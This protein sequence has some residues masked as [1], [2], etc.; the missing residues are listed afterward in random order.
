MK[1]RV[2]TNSSSANVK[3]S[4]AQLSKRIQL[5][6]SLRNF[7]GPVALTIEASFNAICHSAN[8]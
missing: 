6:G 5:G 3:S 2:S 7:L 8:K 1:R 4:K